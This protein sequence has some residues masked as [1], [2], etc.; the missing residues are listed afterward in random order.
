MRGE[1]AVGGDRPARETSTG[2][3]LVE[4]EEP[5]TEQPVEGGILPE[6]AV[7]TGV[8]PEV[9]DRPRLGWGG[10]RHPQARVLKVAFISGF[11]DD[12]QCHAAEAG[13]PAVRGGRR[14]EGRA[15]TWLRASP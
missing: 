11:S 5:F 13:A 1:G 4:D 12:W 10:Q 14:R 7:A 6:P 3:C 8:A 15:P 9:D 2:G